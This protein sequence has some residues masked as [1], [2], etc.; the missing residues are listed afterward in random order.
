MKRF[1]CLTCEKTKRVRV[2]NTDVVEVG[3]RKEGTCRWH[4]L[5]GKMTHGKEMD[6]GR[7]HHP[8]TFSHKISAA[9]QKQKSKR[10]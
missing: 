8:V 2:F 4:D 9:T 3:P 1:Y 6:R 10:K 7:V 5:Q